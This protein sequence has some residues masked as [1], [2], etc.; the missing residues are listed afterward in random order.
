MK[1]DDLEILGA[2]SSR[3]P[4]KERWTEINILWDPYRMEYVLETLGCSAVEGEVTFRREERTIAPLW[5]VEQL[6]RRD[7]AG[8]AFFPRVALKALTEAAT[9]DD[10]FKEPLQFALRRVGN[11]G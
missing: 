1:D 10:A 8:V 6:L 5:V 3:H 11:R 9:V 2:A 4:L 7:K